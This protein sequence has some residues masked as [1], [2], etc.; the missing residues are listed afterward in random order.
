VPTVLD[1]GAI[2]TT[3]QA[4]AQYRNTGKHLGKFG[5]DADAT[6]ASYKLHEQLAKEY[7]DRYGEIGGQSILPWEPAPN[8]GT[9]EGFTNGYRTGDNSGKTPLNAN[10]LASLLAVIPQNR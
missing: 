6:E 8:I 5:N 1:N 9:T 3:D 4:I 7:A 10:Q 2:G